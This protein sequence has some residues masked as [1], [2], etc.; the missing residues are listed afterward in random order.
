MVAQ[1]HFLIG[2]NILDIERSQPLAILD[3]LLHKGVLDL[4]CLPKDGKR[5]MYVWIAE[6]AIHHLK[7]SLEFV[8][9][10]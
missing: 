10:L 6:F 9:E 2:V 5:L 1:I 4:Y 3:V 8:V 7:N